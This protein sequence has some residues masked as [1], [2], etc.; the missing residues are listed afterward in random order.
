MGIMTV[1]SLYIRTSIPSTHG[2]TDRMTGWIPTVEVPWVP[3]R[4][5]VGYWLSV[6]LPLASAIFNFPERVVPG[7]LLLRYGTESWEFATYQRVLIDSVGLSQPFKAVRKTIYLVTGW[8]LNYVPAT[9]PLAV[10]LHAFRHASHYR[11]AGID[12]PERAI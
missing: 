10:A 11:F 5:S 9:K 1:M 12:H 6:Q 4:S 8:L 3:S 2:A 7:N